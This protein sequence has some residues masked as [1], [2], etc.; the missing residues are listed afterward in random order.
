MKQ[1]VKTIVDSIEKEI[2]Y[3]KEN[4][5]LFDTEPSYEREFNYGK[6]TFEIEIKLVHSVGGDWDEQIVDELIKID[7]KSVTVT[8]E[9]N[10][11]LINLSNEVFNQLEITYTNY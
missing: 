8:N 10:K 4:S 9:N 5:H 11:A 2:E 3:I 7:F 1:S 6:F